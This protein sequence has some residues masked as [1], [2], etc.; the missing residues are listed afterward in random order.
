M[1]HYNFKEDLNEGNKGENTVIEHLKNNGGTLVSKN[2]DNRFDALILKNGEKISYEIKTD[3][4][5]K[6]NNDTGNIF[7]EIE[8]RGKDSGIIV[9][10]A[11][12]FVTY[13]KYLDEIWYIKTKK[14]LNLI[15]ENKKSIKFISYSGDSGSNTKGWLIPRYH[16]FNDFLVFD[17]KSL[18]KKKVMSEIKEPQIDF[19]RVRD[20]Y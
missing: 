13:Y 5:C 6:P 1:A 11:K 14:L 15:E 19:N 18:T 12:W 8:C 17:S 4:F 16:F 9:T 2:N 20:I 7:I 10:E 3:V